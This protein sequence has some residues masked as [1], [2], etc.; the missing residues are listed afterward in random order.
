MSFCSEDLKIGVSK[1]LPNHT[2]L[3]EMM[4]K[5]FLYYIFENKYSRKVIII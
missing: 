4:K 1:M 2:I 3:L 5:E